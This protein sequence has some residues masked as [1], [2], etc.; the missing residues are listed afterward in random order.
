MSQIRLSAAC[1]KAGV[2][3]GFDDFAEHV[4]HLVEQAAPNHPDFLIF[5][6]LLTLEL[7]SSFENARSPDKYF[8]VASYTDAYL[9]LFVHLA[10]ENSF[11]ILGGSHLR[12]ADGKLYNTSHLFTPDGQIIEQRKCHLFPVVVGTSSGN[13]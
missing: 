12:E 6:E 10:K 13:K 11:Y 4:S 2:V 9:D 1:F 3:D 5:P 8:R 7:I